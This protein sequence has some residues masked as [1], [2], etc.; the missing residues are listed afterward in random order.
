MLVYM[1]RDAM[2]ALT[3]SRHSQLHPVMIVFIGIFSGPDGIPSII[4]PSL[5]GAGDAGRA[6]RSQRWSSRSTLEAAENPKADST[7]VFG[8]MHQVLLI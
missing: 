4:K 6:G 5:L 3:V 7:W 2:T 1:P 8:G